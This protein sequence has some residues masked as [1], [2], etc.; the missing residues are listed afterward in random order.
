[1]I[2]TAALLAASPARAQ[3][4]PEKEPEATPD[5]TPEATPDTTPDSAPDT[6][7]GAAPESPPDPAP[8]AEPEAQAAK[9]RATDQELSGSL[10]LDVGGRLSPGGLHV[11]GAY[12]YQLSDLDW[13]DGGLSFTFGSGQAAC[14]RDRDNDFLCDHG[15]LDGF[16][17]EASGGVRR[18][19]PGQGKF[20]PY[21]RVG[22][23]LRLVSFSGDDVRGLAIPLQLGGGV[24]ARVSDRIYV[25][26]G[27]E[28]RVGPAFFDSGLGTQP[29]LGLAVH[30]GVEFAL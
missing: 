24:R 23:G 26:G 11:A 2:A 28:L 29:H 16:G 19:F 9:P 25:T 20:T 12:L 17:A 14:F 13:F 15:S 7:P 6:T 8:G 1:M 10:G 21:A 5:A 22:L 18:Y 3:P 30:G 27:A 4:V